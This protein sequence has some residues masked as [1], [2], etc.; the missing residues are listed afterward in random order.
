MP[1]KNHDSELLLNSL[2][3]VFSNMGSEGREG[4]GGS[5]LSNFSRVKGMLSLRGDVVVVLDTGVLV[6][7]VV[8]P[9]VDVDDVSQLLLDEDVL[10]F[11]FLRFRYSCSPIW[12]PPGM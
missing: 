5:F 12:K 1:K 10:V 9:D 4:R 2:C 3:S 6:G 8:T 11:S 7:L